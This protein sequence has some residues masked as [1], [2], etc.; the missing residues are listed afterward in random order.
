LKKDPGNYSP[1]F[2]PWES[3]RT[4]PPGSY[5]KSN[6]ACDWEKPAQ[7][8]QGQIMLDKPDGLLQQSNLFG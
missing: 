1:N 7:I 3:Y 6:E 4:N 2:S 5:N 8:H